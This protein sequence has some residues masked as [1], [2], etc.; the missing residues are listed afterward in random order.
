MTV[1]STSTTHRA[2][3]MGP[4]GKKALESKMSRKA[5]NNNV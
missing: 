2:N 4:E 5:A 3:K 1:V